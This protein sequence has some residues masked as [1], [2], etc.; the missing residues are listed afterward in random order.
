VVSE[1]PTAPK[2]SFFVTNATYIAKKTGNDSAGA[3]LVDT[4]GHNQN[5]VAKRIQQ[6]LGASATVTDITTVRKSVGSSLTAVDLAGLTRVELTFALLIAAA[7]GALVLGL[8]LAERRRSL[9]IATALGA[10]PRHLRA[11]IASETL[12]LGIG[13]LAGGAITGW[14]L[15]EMLTKVLTGVF[16]PP[17]SALAVP[18]AYLAWVSALTATALALVTAAAI[19]NTRRPAIN[20]LRRL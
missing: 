17:P 20:L 18:W 15:S 7:A 6:L 4:G 3:F 9:A 2:D 11:F 1:F 10:R 19:R 16:D 5:A 13:G 12:I 8:G 14:A